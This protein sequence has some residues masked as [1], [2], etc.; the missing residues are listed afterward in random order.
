[1]GNRVGTPAVGNIVGPVFNV[2]KFSKS[3][4]SCCE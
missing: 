2:L 4:C 1:M 3:I